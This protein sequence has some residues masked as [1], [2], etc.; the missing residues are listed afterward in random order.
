VTRILTVLDQIVAQIA[1]GVN[2]VISGGYSL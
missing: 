2:H 1:K